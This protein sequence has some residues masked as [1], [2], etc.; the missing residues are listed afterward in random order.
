MV[1]RLL[2][3]EK[4]AG[5]N[6]VFRSSDWGKSPEDQ[7]CSN[8]L[9]FVATVLTEIFVMP[10]ISRFYGIVIQMYLSEH[11]QHK[12]HFHALYGDY[13]ASIGIETGEFFAGKLP[14]RAARIVRDWAKSHRA[15]LVANWKRVRR[16]ELPTPIA[17]LE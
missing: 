4:V 3:K 15:E 16:G 12:P 13:A 2:A 9:V 8:G 10:T 1:E 6:P 5:S 7:P 14:R 17:P 11:G